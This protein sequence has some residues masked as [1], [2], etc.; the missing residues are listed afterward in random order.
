MMTHPHIAQRIAALGAALSLAACNGVPFSTQWKLRQFEV[1][2]ADFAEL[3]VA[4]RGPDWASPT[5]ETAR[6]EISYWR[7]DEEETTKRQ[8]TVRLQ[9]GAHAGDAAPLRELAG[10]PAPVVYEASARDL[11]SIRAAQEEVQRWR[12]SGA[13]AKG[14]IHL[15]GSLACR[16][17][18]QLPPGPILIDVFFHADAETGWLPLYAQHNVLDDA[19]EKDPAKVEESLPLCGKSAA[20]AL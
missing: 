1:A 20:R 8:F 3:R 13:R 6:V 17:V 10:P 5:P 11:A 16:R 18:T 14:K 2:K 15:A 7:D 4:L 12:E 19:E 9:R